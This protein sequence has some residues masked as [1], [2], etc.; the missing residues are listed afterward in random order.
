MFS[1]DQ[2]KDLK[3]SAIAVLKLNYH[4]HFT[5]PSSKLYP[6]QWNWDSAFIAIGLSH[7]DEK[8]AQQ[9]IISLIT[10]QWS[11]GM[12]PHILYSDTSKDYL[13]NA[14]FWGSNEIKESPKNKFTS[15]ITQ[16]PVLSFAALK[17]YENSKDKY[18]AKEFLKEIYPKLFSYQRFLN[19][20]RDFFGDGLISVLHPWE[21]GL[22]NSPRWDSCLRNI[23]INNHTEINRVD[24]KLVA[25]HQRPTDKDYQ[26]YFFIAE[27]LREDNYRIGDY[28][29]LPFV[30]Q[31]VMFNALALQSLESLINICELIEEESAQ[32]VNWH[33]KLSEV[34]NKKLWSKHNNQ[35]LDWDVI[36]N[37]PIHK[38]SLANCIPIVTD[39]ITKKQKGSIVN[40]L[41]KNSTF[42]KAGSYPL[43]TIPFTSPEFNPQNYWRGPAWI[44]MNWLIIQGLNKHGFIEFAKELS[45][46]TIRLVSESGFYEYF[47]PY[48]GVGCGSDNFSWTAALIIDLITNLQAEQ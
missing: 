10:G 47:D 42:W 15:G 12:I 18:T 3:H 24:N 17:I 37:E 4:K 7:F 30:I 20:E 13:P 44:N 27:K 26:L 6:Y 33:D 45:I 1:E 41:K 21:S 31:D 35:F 36:S 16:P 29:K 46:E 40:H 39:S 23:Q 19:V 9:E 48:T 8:R 28:S 5:K 32:L 43:S 25:I 11:N 38:L 22:D 34:L 14:N 2:L